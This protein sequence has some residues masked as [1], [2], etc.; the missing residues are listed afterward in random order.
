[1]WDNP[2]AVELEKLLIPHIKIASHTTIK[3]INYLNLV[4]LMRKKQ[5][6]FCS[7]W[8]LF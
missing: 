7:R 2:I 1:M 4:T 6:T 8:C 3:T 5:V